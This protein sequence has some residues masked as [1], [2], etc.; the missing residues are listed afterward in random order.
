VLAIWGGADEGI[1]PEVVKAFDAAMDAAGKEHRTVVYP[2]APHSFFDRTA[3]EH[4]AASEDAW[5]EVLDFVGVT[6][7]ATK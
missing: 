6:G 4:A 7:S 2:G 3:L 1:G 5:R